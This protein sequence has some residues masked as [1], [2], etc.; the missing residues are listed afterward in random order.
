MTKDNSLAKTMDISRQ[1]PSSDAV[2][3]FAR[4][5]D[6]LVKPGARVGIAVSGG[7]DSLALLLLAAAARPGHVEA[8][9]VDHALR[10]EAREEAEMVAAICEQLGVPHAILTVEWDEKP[11]TAIQERAR[12]ARYRLL[13]QWA[14]ER[15]IPALL[16]AHH[17]DDQAETFF[18]RLARG[19]GVRGLGGMRPVTSTPGS[20]VAVVRPLLGWRRA[21]LEQVCADCGLSPAA[22]PSNEDEQFERVRV[23]KALA[24]VDWLDA[25]SVALSADYLAQADAALQWA[26]TQEWDRAVSNGNGAIV[27]RPAGAPPEIRRRIARRAVMRL[28]T[29]GNGA[30]LRGPELERLLAVLTS[31]RKATLRGVLCAGGSEWRF[32][33]APARAPARRG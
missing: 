8:A 27:Y 2:E 15:S 29:E 30:D 14:R 12:F 11:G 3:R 5:L 1:A 19:A 20:T 18:M 4:R 9:T 23:R 16:T 6:R 24:G 33:P 13:G 21:E 22:D 10:P 17:V 26:T 7:P 32:T 28:A 25:K 31:G